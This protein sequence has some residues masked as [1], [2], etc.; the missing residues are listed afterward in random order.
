MSDS[1]AEELGV[2][3]PLRGDLPLC[4]RGA[5]A[6]RLRVIFCLRGSNRWNIMSG[7]TVICGKLWRGCHQLHQATGCKMFMSVE[8]TI[9]T[10]RYGDAGFLSCKFTEEI[11]RRNRLWGYLKRRRLST[12][13]AFCWFHGSLQGGG[14]F[15]RGVGRTI[16]LPP[17]QI[18]LGWVRVFH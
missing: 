1:K 12:W 7:F 16:Q 6:L 10:D 8:D 9:R 14:T 17:L 11:H 5:T 2:L 18:L 15:F 3:R 4:L 13:L